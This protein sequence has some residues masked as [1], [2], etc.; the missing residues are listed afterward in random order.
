MVSV[1]RR[2]RRTVR[3]TGVFCATAASVELSLAG[4]DPIPLVGWGPGF[5][6]CA[7]ATSDLSRVL[8]VH[9]IVFDDG[10]GERLALVTA[11]IW[12]G[13]ELVTELVAASLPESCGLDG[14]RII[15]SGTH[16]HS[17]PSGGFDSEYYAT[18]SGSFPFDDHVGPDLTNAIARGVK[19]AIVLACDKLAGGPSSETRAV[20][21]SASTTS[22]G[23][24]INRS[25]VAYSK[26]VESGLGP[27]QGLGEEVQRACVERAAHFLVV[28]RAEGAQDLIAVW[29]TVNAHAAALPKSST[30]LDGDYI[31]ALSAR[32]HQELKVPIALAGGAI[33][34]VDPQP[35]GVLR[36]VFLEYREKYPHIW[37]AK[38]VDAIAPDMVSAVRGAQA[39]FAPSALEVVTRWPTIAG[40]SLDEGD[41]PEEAAVGLSVLGG[42]ELGRG[43]GGREGLEPSIATHPPEGHGRKQRHSTGNLVYDLALKAMN[44]LMASQPRALPLKLVRFGKSL[45]LVGLPGEPTTMFVR[46]LVSRLQALGADQ[47]IVAGVTGSYHGYFVTRAEYDVQHYEGASCVWGPLTEAFVRRELGRMATTAESQADER[48]GELRYE[49]YAASPGRGLRLL[50]QVGLTYYRATPP[51]LLRTTRIKALSTP[52]F[53]VEPWAISKGGEA[54]FLVPNTGLQGVLEFEDGRTLRFSR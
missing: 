53:R 36:S 5:S 42:S 7:D 4:I 28:R 34:D 8:R 9:A 25:I 31:G 33:G 43:L 48:P 29:G 13:S 3:A 32:L 40:A 49:S 52:R 37:L 24:H 44:G 10:L 46:R 21:A 12:S 26:N 41:V 39:T 17:G 22:L 20:L 23:P 14:T 27:T 19:Q 47:V 16:T 15:F 2:V 11:D 50:E 18:F 1:Q 35:Q 38:L 54:L 51:P 6:R 45:W 30:R